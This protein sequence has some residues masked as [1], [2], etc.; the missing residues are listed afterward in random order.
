MDPETHRPRD[1]PESS[2]IAEEFP[3]D[4][5]HERRGTADETEVPV[6]PRGM[7]AEHRADESDGPAGS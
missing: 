3:V 7:P 6:P 5:A 4:P 2:E 1:E